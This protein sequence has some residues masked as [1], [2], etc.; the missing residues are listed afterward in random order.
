MIL[1]TY[2][3]SHAKL[4]KYG[5]A[6][7][8]RDTILT[9]IPIVGRYGDP[10]RRHQARHEIDYLERT[11]CILKDTRR[12]THSLTW[13]GSNLTYV[14]V[15]RTWESFFLINLIKRDLTFLLIPHEYFAFLLNLHLDYKSIPSLYAPSLCSSLSWLFRAFLAF[16]GLTL[17]FTITFF[18]SSAPPKS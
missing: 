9:M 1:N 2:S 13:F 16:Y 6:C 15:E 8:T 12:R 4:Y 14:H 7:I 3:P 18:C 11:R 10:H 17:L 5:V